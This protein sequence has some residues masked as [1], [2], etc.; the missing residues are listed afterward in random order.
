MRWRRGWS[1]RPSQL[2]LPR[3][4]LRAEATA[5]SRPPAAGPRHGPRFPG[6]GGA[7]ERSW[8]L[9]PA[10]ASQ[11]AERTPVQRDGQRQ[12]DPAALAAPPSRR[13]AGRG[14][15]E[16]VGTAPRR[17]RASWGGGHP[18]SGSGPWTE[19]RMTRWGKNAPRG[20]SRLDCQ[21][22]RA[23]H[24]PAPPHRGEGPRA[25]SPHRGR[26]ERRTL[27]HSRL[28]SGCPPVSVPP[29]LP[30]SL[31]PSLSAAS[32]CLPPLLLPSP[33]GLRVQAALCLSQGI[34]PPRCQE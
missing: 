4:G 22:V 24:S 16:A 6:P 11:P 1:A 21:N 8:P 7:A 20:E 9:A 34:Q 5:G 18:G 12:R 13:G 33:S 25:A 2:C 28:F 29:S 15:G 19:P 17:L 14:A 23:Y 10:A 30:P 26:A 31:C 3:A 32:P 27:S